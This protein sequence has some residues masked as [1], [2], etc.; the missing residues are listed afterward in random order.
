MNDLEYLALKAKTDDEALKELFKNLLNDIKKMSHGLFIA[1]G[2]ESDIIQEARIGLWKAVMDFNPEAGMSFK[3]FAVNVC[4]K[5]HLITSVSHANRK[6]YIVHNSANS[7]DAPMSYDDD[8]KLSD[9]IQDFTHDMQLEYADQ[10]AFSKHRTALVEHLTRLEINVLD[11]YIQHY[12]YKEIAQELNV[13]MKAVD[14]SLSRVRA[15]A[16]LLDLLNNTPIENN[17]N[18]IEE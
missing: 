1:G 9:T 11:L 8:T 16:Q 6:K 17:T 7:L 18:D 3:N 4:I 5:R 12:T 14:N 10:E 13:K 15:K 2:D